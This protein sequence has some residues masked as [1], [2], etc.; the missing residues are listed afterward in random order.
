MATPMNSGEGLPCGVLDPDFAEPL[1]GKLSLD[2]GFRYTL[3]LDCEDESLN[4]SRVVGSV[5][6]EP[7]DCLS[8]FGFALLEA[9]LSGQSRKTSEE[10][11]TLVFPDES[12]RN[13][14][15]ALLERLQTDHRS[16][17]RRGASLLTWLPAGCVVGC[18]PGC[19]ARAKPPGVP[20]DA[21]ENSPRLAIRSEG[22]IGRHRPDATGGHLEEFKAYA[23]QLWDRQSASSSIRV[24]LRKLLSLLVWIICLRLTV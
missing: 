7:R 8:G 6:C 5:R 24:L 1:D 17:R 12:S 19:M 13:A 23:R 4:L 14:L 9:E 10:V 21:S 2:R 18:L 15:L 3:E 11:R 22:S 16:F 20:H